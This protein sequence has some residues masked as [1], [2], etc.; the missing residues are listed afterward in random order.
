MF[1]ST[2][3]WKFKQ[4]VDLLLLSVA[5]SPVEALFELLVRI[6]KQCKIVHDILNTSHC[7]HREL[8]HTVMV[9][10]EQGHNVVGGE[11]ALTPCVR[12]LQPEVGQA[13]AGAHHCH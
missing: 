13:K 12:P 8:A 11:G 2:K 10:G 7:L 1:L 4:V 3:R 5:I 6:G 9:L